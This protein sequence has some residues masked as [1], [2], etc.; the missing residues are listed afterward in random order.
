MYDRRIIAAHFLI[1]DSQGLDVWEVNRPL[2]PGEAS[3]NPEDY[4]ARADL[5]IA[6]MGMVQE[7]LVPAPSEDM[8]TVFY[9]AGKATYGRA[10]LRDWFRDIYY[11]LYHRPDG[12]RVGN[13]VEVYGVDN[14]LDQM[15]QRMQN[16]LSVDI[17]ASCASM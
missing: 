9:D 10:Q 4:L 11:M 5:F 14:F 2:E 15:H 16:P 6:A 17:P 1:C 13:L 12:V 8:M 7:H 3:P